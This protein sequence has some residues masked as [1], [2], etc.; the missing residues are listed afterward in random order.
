M[1]KKFIVCIWAFLVLC[2]LF[3]ACSIPKAQGTEVVWNCTLQI[4]EPGGKRDDV[5]FGEAYDAWDGPPVDSYDMVKPP[6]PLVP[7]LRAWFDDNLPAPYNLL[8][9]DYRYFPDTSKTWNVSIQWIPS[10]YSSSTT[11]TIAWDLP[12]TSASG[13]S[14]MNLSTSS[15][16]FLANMLIENIYTFTCPAN[17]LQT[18]Q[19]ICMRTDTP[20]GPP[21]DDTNQTNIPPVADASLS[22]QDGVVGAFVLFNGS[23]SYDSD[24]YLTKWFWEFGD[25][26][27]GSG[28]IT[29]HVYHDIGLYTVTL[30]VTDNKGA[31]ADDTIT[32]HIMTANQT[33]TKPVI[34][35]TRIGTKNTPYL[36]TVSSTDP[37]NDF[38]QYRI[39]LGDGTSHE[40]E[41]V[42]NNTVYS[43]SHCWN[44]SGK[45]V[46]SVKATDN[47]TLSEETTF[48]IFIDVLFVRL[49]GFLYDGNDDG[50]FDTFY[51]NT[52]G[53]T[54]NAHQLENGSYLLDTDGDGTWNYLYN[55]STGSLTLM[56]TGLTTIENPW[57]FIIIIIV[58]I[59]IIAGIVYLYKRNYF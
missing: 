17:M 57:L 58:A 20:P 32:V 30:T 29:T 8:W 44:A 55:P 35:G 41:F 37:E 18:F 9:K 14:S 2:V 10:D 21:N 7:Y 1:K 5:V 4:S 39:T 11:V 40:S 15:G 22:E 16:I 48:E 49:L 51:S 27:N 25:G 46:I 53:R 3:T 42:P 23:R 34:T 52:T 12:E 19:I 31:T 36:Y 6:A 24:G 59:A 50:L 47:I 45:Y 56:I 43:F 13:Y 33:P 28:E 54:T 38:L 26:A